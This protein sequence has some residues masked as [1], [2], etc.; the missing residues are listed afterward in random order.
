MSFLGD[1][2]DYSLE[3]D[4]KCI[5][6]IN[7]LIKKNKT[8]E[9]ALRKAINKIMENPEHFKPLHYPLQGM[10]RVHVLGS[11]VLVYEIKGNVV[12]L[13]RFKHHDYAYK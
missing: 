12:R 1:H 13:L 4:E 7:D 11:F 10:R 9:N 2:L 6:Q 8:L 5:S 3:Y